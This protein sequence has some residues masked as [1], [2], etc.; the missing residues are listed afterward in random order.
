VEEKAAS[1]SLPDANELLGDG[2]EAGSE[3]VPGAAAGGTAGDA[4]AARGGRESGPEDEKELDYGTD[5]TSS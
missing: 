1:V 2:L 3:A 5:S 4:D